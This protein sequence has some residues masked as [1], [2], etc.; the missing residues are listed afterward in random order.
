MK[1]TFRNLALLPLRL[2]L[3]V[4]LLAALLLGCAAPPAIAQSPA[5]GSDR[6]QP[7]RFGDPE[8]LA[9]D[10]PFFPG[11]HYDAAIP[12]PDSLLGQ[13][14]GT[15]LSHH[16]EVL[17]C[18]R[19]IAASSKRVRLETFAR[20]HEGR[21]LVWVA[22]SSPANLAKL[23]A[24]RADLARLADPRGLAEP[25]A[26]RILAG[27]AI[28]WMGYSIHGDE[29][30]G[31]DAAVA[32]AYHLAAA[33]DPAVVA[34]LESLVIV[35]DPCLNPD[36]R[37]RII[38]MVEQS[39]GRTP[40]L[41]YASMHRGRWP[42][43]RG[44]HYLF[45]M[46]RDWMAGTQ[47]ETRG[48]WQAVLSFHPQLFV[49]AHEMG[50]D[51]TFLFYP[52]A[53][54]FNPNLPTTELAWQE[55]YSADAARAFD[56]HGWA[57][58][59]REWADAWGP[60]Y[61]DSWAALTGATGILYEQANTTGFP[62]K[63]PS[64][65]VLTYREAVHHQLTASWANL[66]T[67]R[68]RRSD[69]LRD[70][71]ANGR[72]NVA[73]ETPGNS[74]LLVVKPHGNLQ[75]EEA[76]LQTLLGQAIEVRRADAEFEAPSV[77]WAEGGHAE[78]A[79]FP[80]GSWLVA[81]RQPARQRV[82]AFLDFDIR[83]DKEALQ[84]E[85]EELERK[86]RSKAYDVT[87]WSLPHALDLDAAWVDAV[88]VRSTPVVTSELPRR[89]L[90]EIAVTEPAPVA[91]MVDANND[92]ALAFAARALELGLA[93]HASDE[94]FTAGGQH[95]ARGS[96]LVRR[97]ENSGSAQEIWN[98][99]R[100]AANFARVDAVA[101]PSG[102]APDSEQ[103]DLGGQHFHLLARP[104]VALLANSPVSNDG[105]G[106]LWHH[107]D[108]RIGVPFSILD[109]Q[110]LGDYDLRRFNVLILPPADGLAKL[111]EPHKEAL[112][113]WLENGGTLIACG[114]SAAE[115]TKGRLGLSQVVLRADAL[116]ELE[117][118]H[119]DAERERGA[120]KVEIDEAAVWDGT[121]AKA[122]SAATQPAKEG[123]TDAVAD[124]AATPADPAASTTPASTT[125]THK[126]TASKNPDDAD[127]TNNKVNKDDE[128]HA[129]LFS[130]QGATLRGLVNP[131]AW[132]T[133]GVDAVLP[134]LAFGSDIFL[135]KAPVT[136]AVR[137]D[138]GPTLRLGGLLWPEARTRLADSS[139]L[140]VERKGHGQ[141][142]LFAAPPTFRGYHLATA[143]L[144]ANA[145]VLGPGLGADQPVGW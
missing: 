42:F 131:D 82:R 89:D 140:T 123:A 61:S 111:L 121:T 16:A 113:S 117:S 7:I 137:L 5:P 68:D 134:V 104:R 88:E 12:T 86:G 105:Y 112:A 73:A 11:A 29:L 9:W 70:Y 116:E 92:D 57:Y 80:A 4:P 139:W 76:F 58:Y 130:P 60:F 102:R 30:S 24:I 143:R 55:R 52:Q 13:R 85:R 97:S 144:F 35:I 125:T 124:P 27:P 2:A 115:L 38:G 84:L 142:V 136:T 132:I 93:V 95:F 50:S 99:V 122:P 49:D 119:R 14:H 108:Q 23:D 91:W 75:R 77:D 40:S 96:F 64:G 129:A 19:A 66:G 1:T 79:T 90:R 41:D 71:L 26:Q 114:S 107:L 67:L 118:F 47:P 39:A 128:T 74:R 126:V 138:L 48:R 51:D 18:L 20:T 94:P 17:A 28:A 43:G 8:E 32:L 56:A 83:Y 78:K 45:D 87:S 72:A 25:E 34:L 109:A 21:E 101:A 98:H 135:A 106:N 10:S 120:R 110:S 15:R 37:E 69:A 127:D 54:P 33:Q 133:S 46:N 100:A 6:F 62:L 31:S 36:G 81:A 59:T 141:I 103:A 63:R 145:V 65:R 53:K 22:I 44:N 3:L